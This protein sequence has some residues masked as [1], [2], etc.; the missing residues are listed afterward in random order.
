MHNFKYFCWLTG[1]DW[2]IWLSRVQSTRAPSNVILS[3][4]STPC[5]GAESGNDETSQCSGSAFAVLGIFPR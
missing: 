4:A 1:V 3:C 2:L 5:L